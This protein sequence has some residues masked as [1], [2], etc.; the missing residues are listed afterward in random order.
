MNIQV[1]EVPLYKTQFQR[2]SC[3]ETHHVLIIPLHA[4]LQSIPVPA[5]HSYNKETY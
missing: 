1:I 2:D 4:Q 5:F 3:K